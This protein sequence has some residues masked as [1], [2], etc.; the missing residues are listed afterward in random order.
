MLYARFVSRSKYCPGNLKG[1]TR[2]PS[3]EGFS[4]GTSLPKGSWLSQRHTAAPALLVISR[5]VFR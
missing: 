4:L 2:V 5:G 1:T 3:P